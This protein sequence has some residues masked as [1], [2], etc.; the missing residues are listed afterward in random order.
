MSR[1][2]ST[3]HRQTGAPIIKIES[4]LRNAPVCVKMFHSRY[5]LVA[6]I[7]H[8]QSLC[9]QMCA[10]VCVCVC[11]QGVPG[12]MCQTSGGCSLC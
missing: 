9:G 5:Y 3:S 8:I 1:I 4:T 11:V 6:T 7:I 10:C 2:H 12:G